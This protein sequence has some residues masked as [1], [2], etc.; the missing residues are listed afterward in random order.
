M[1]SLAFL[2]L[3]FMALLYGCSSGNQNAEE[4][5]SANTEATEEIPKGAVAYVDLNDPLDQAMVSEGKAIFDAQCS[6]CHYLDT[7]T[8]TGPGWAGI[9]NRR[10]PDWIMNMILNVDLMLEVDSLAHSLLQEAQV[11]MPDQRLT[12]ERSRSVL[13]FMRQN[14]LDKTGA[15][16]KG[17]TE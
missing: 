15:K 9:T 7:A 4:G 2:T 14:D 1:K 11:E 3:I 13:E 17:A 10:E 6:K 12:V 16:D 5:V 8:L